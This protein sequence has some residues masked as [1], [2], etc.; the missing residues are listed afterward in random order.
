MEHTIFLDSEKINSTRQSLNEK[1]NQIKIID[2]SV[3]PQIIQWLVDF[4]SFL[5]DLKNG[6]FISNSNRDLERWAYY[7]IESKPYLYE[8][9]GDE[10]NVLTEKEYQIFKQYISY[11]ELKDDLNKKSTD[12]EDEITYEFYLV[13]IKSLEPIFSALKKG[14]SIRLNNSDKYKKQFEDLKKH[15]EEFYLD[16][17]NDN[18]TKKNQN[19]I[20][21]ALDWHPFDNDD[22]KD[23]YIF[24]ETKTTNKNKIFFSYVREFLESNNML[25]LENKT[26]LDDYFK[27]I[28]ERNDFQGKDVVKHQHNLASSHPLQTKF[29]KDLEVY[30]KTVKKIPRI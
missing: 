16:V 30:E 6:V 28:N 9:M 14:I 8:Y 10:E 20:P 17:V 19:P 3:T 7:L 4:F 22:I 15:I 2:D 18:S 23:F 13:K 29:A 24:L 1:F 11:C 5:E 25:L 26:T 12:L 21:K 27:W